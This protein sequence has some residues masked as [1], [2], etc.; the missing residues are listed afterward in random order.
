MRVWLY[1]VSYRRCIW[2]QQSVLHSS[3]YQQILLASTRHTVAG[4]RPGCEGKRGT[5]R[6][7]VRNERKQPWH[8]LTP[9]C[10]Q[11]CPANFPQNAGA[12]SLALNRLAEA[13]G[14]LAAGAD[15]SSHHVMRNPLHP[16][17]TAGECIVKWCIQ[18]GNKLRAP[19]G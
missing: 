2:H 15:V 10:Y 19:E 16:S 7:T 9:W 1:F 3:E 11:P 5:D 12:S 8:F 6:R 18:K 17:D 14:P 4:P 13:A